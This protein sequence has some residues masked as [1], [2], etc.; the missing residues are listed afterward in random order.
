[1]KVFFKSL[2][3]IVGLLFA[4]IVIS[5]IMP[6]AGAI[7]G[8]GLLVIPLIAVFKPIPSIGLSRKGFCI[9]LALLVGL[10][11]SLLSWVYVGDLS[12]LS[13]LKVSNPTAYLS[14]IKKTDKAKWL[15]ELSTL[16]PEQHVLEVA[17]AVE[18][19]AVLKAAVE[20]ELNKHEEAS[21]ALEK[22]EHDRE[23]A[24]KIDEKQSEVTKY[25]ELLDREISSIPNV[26]MSKYTGSGKKINTGM[27]LLNTW[28][29]AY[30]NGAT[31]P[32][33]VQGE[34]KR[35]KFR[36]LVVKKHKLGFPILRDAYGPA[37]R[38]NLWESNGSA[39]TIG[40]GYRTVEFVSTVFANNANIKK[41]QTDMHENL[42][43]LRFTR[44]EYKWIKHAS[45][46]TYYTLEP[47]K[48]TDLVIWEDDGGFRLA[49]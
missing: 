17:K 36:S 37:A 47:P 29:M 14:E 3:I 2:G 19:E 28:A 11:A 8:L 12:R 4:V 9:S 15:D 48:D 10:P 33:D 6:A 43:M 23:E 31:L 24:Q 7:A 44:A 34:Q 13:E 45:E 42:L 40:A 41:I 35:Q 18:Q 26:S 32:L 46:F 30:D 25:L 49:K 21:K 38:K 22:E 5:A 27:L 39:R 20:K 16:D 1:M